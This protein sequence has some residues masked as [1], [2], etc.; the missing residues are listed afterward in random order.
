M[1]AAT[2]L[3]ILMSLG[4]K[5]PVAEIVKV[6]SYCHECDI[7]FIVIFPNQASALD[8]EHS[9]F[10]LSYLPFWIIS[11]DLVLAPPPQSFQLVWI[12]KP[13]NYYEMPSIELSMYTAS[14]ALGTTDKALYFTKL[15]APSFMT[16]FGAAT[17]NLLQQYNIDVLSVTL[18]QKM[19]NKKPNIFLRFETKG[20]KLKGYI[21]ETMKNCSND[22]EHEHLIISCRCFVQ[23]CC[24]SLK[25]I[26]E[27]ER[28]SYNCCEL[29]FV[30][31]K[32]FHRPSIGVF[33]ALLLFLVCITTLWN[34]QKDLE[35]NLKTSFDSRKDLLIS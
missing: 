4:L 34:V 8:F 1:I 32:S 3:Q 14:C 24:L 5:T 35:S 31:C 17:C 30:R 18:H 19:A 10:P 12:W 33:Q 23:K 25:E 27:S 26:C 16:S 15:N 9:I 28:K 21:K 2:L 6:N 11:D 20:N 7:D 29:K 22:N 13:L